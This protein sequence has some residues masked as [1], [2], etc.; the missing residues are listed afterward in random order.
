MHF[1]V[2]ITENK[3]IGSNCVCIL[4]FER[5]LPSDPQWK[6]GPPWCPTLS[7][8]HS[9]CSLNCTLGV[10]QHGSPHRRCSSQFTLHQ[11][12]WEHQPMHFSTVLSNFGLSHSAKKI[13]LILIFLILNEIAGCPISQFHLYII[14]W[15]LSVLPFFLLVVSIFL[16]YSG[17][18][19]LCRQLILYQ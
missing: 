5:F 16:F 15:E 3:I 19:K 13:L 8:H 14:F 9:N 10:G 18:F 2:H 6:F 4:N 7:G 17:G 12:I 11:Q 1:F